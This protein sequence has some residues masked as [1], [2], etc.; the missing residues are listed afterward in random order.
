MNPPQ[1]PAHRSLQKH[2]SEGHNYALFYLHEGNN[3]FVSVDQSASK[4]PR[5]DC[6]HAV[7]GRR[8]LP[9]YDTEFGEESNSVTVLTATKSKDGN[10]I[11]II[12]QVGTR[13]EVTLYIAIWRVHEGLDFEEPRPRPWAH[14]V[15][16][17]FVSGVSKTNRIQP[18]VFDGYHRVYCPSG[19]FNLK[20][21]VKEQCFDQLPQAPF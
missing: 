15:M 20:D 11:G 14:K 1:F 21:G 12:Y 18:M 19:C 3:A 10:Y 6:Q 13:Q 16:S 9:V 4:L 8:L 5:L 17:Q 2:T 7:S